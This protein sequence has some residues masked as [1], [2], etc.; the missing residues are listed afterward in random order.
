MHRMKLNKIQKV[1]LVQSCHWGPCLLNL[2]K[3]SHS[4]SPSRMAVVE[5][6]L[7]NCD[8]E[9]VVVMDA[10]VDGHLEYSRSHN[11]SLFEE[12]EGL[13]AGTNHHVLVAKVLWEGD[14]NCW[15]RG[16]AGIGLVYIGNN[17]VREG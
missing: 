16:A 15:E 12:G 17:L 13:E 10:V 1:H 9:A 11:H 2:G 8:V 5:V 14:K 4:H 7:S 3:T 6:A